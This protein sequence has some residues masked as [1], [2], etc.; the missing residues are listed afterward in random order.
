MTV[1][2]INLTNVQKTCLPTLYGKALDARVKDSILG[3]TLADQAVQQMDFDFST[4]RLPKAASIS[5]PVRAKQLDGWTREF[6]V[7]N[8]HCIVLHL[9]CGLDTRVYRVD[10][11]TS[12]DW[13][14]VDMPEVI[15]L[16][17]QLY[18]KRRHYKMVSSSITK[19]SWLDHIPTDRPV[20]VVAEGLVMHV[21][22]VELLRLF[23]RITTR[24]PSGEFIFDVYSELTARL[25]TLGSKFTGAPA[26]LHWGLP[27]ALA[28]NVPS[29]R[30]VDAV[31]YLTLPDLVTRLAHTPLSRA[32][33]RAIDAGFTKKSIQ[34]MRYEFG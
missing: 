14:G 29:L 6:I 28:D 27:K 18:P 34:H 22:T 21:P 2:Q 13:Y 32:Y 33:F 23:N 5:L 10:P 16:R 31:P 15:E 4:L 1:G 24:F 17:Q 20:I 19:R 25:I 7:A 8:P 26:H 30:L 9:G 11:P 12:V 3:D